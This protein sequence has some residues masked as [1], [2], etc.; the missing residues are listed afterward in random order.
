M[1]IA[2][3]DD[4]KDGGETNKFDASWGVETSGLLELDVG[5]DG[6]GTSDDVDC[7][8]CCSCKN[9]KVNYKIAIS[10]KNI[11]PCKN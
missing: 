7:C 5:K 2:L 10:R 1:F 4:G 8:C 11:N 9:K 6:P 3:D